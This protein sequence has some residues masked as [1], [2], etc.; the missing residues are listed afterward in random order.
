[1]GVCAGPFGDFACS[2][3]GVWVCVLAFGKAFHTHTTPIPQEPWRPDRPHTSKRTTPKQT[4]PSPTIRPNL[5]I[6]LSLFLFVANRMETPSIQETRG[7]TPL[8]PPTRDAGGRAAR[9]AARTARATLSLGDVPS[10]EAPLGRVTTKQPPRL[11]VGGTPAAYP[12]EGH[13]APKAGWI[14]SSGSPLLP[15]LRNGERSQP[16]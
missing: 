11:P 7:R 5:Y 2:G 16:G 10:D 15:N 3:F 9:L 12:L 14:S 13:F 6:S 1:M 4:K 8:G